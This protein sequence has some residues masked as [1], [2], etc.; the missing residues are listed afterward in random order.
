MQVRLEAFVML[1]LLALPGCDGDESSDAPDTVIWPEGSGDSLDEVRRWFYFIDVNL[2]EDTVFAVEESSYDLAV[3]DAIVTESNNTDYDVASVVSDWHAASHP[4][5]VLA[6][7]DVGQAEDFRTYWQPGWTIGNPAWILG[8]DPD[9]WEGNYPVAYWD[10]QWQALWLDD[11]GMLDIVIEAGFDGIYLDWIEAYSDD[12]VIAAAQ[13]QS[14]DPRAAMIE[15]V[16]ALAQHGRARNPDFVV[17]GQNAAELAARPEYVEVVDGI[18]QEQTWFDGAADGQPPG[19]CP[20]PRDE[21]D[22]DT[23]DYYDS[24]SAPCQA[25]FDEFPD[26]T[27]HVSTEGYLEDLERARDAGL[28]V[29]SVDYAVEPDNIATVYREQRSRGFV[30]F[31]SG[32]LLDRWIEPVP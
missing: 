8:N 21:D 11:G 13:A 19:D 31:T 1:A 14:V 24:L 22:I 30:P 7:I 16:A 29:L 17:V 4:K 27:L 5:L 26:S 3:I 10:P 15:W 2:D 9:G 18:A 32:R 23:D 20:L 25:M 6:Y 28:V 12:N